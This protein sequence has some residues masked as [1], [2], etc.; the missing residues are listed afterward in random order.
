MTNS[1][2]M[3]TYVVN[4]VTQATKRQD[5]KVNLL[6]KTSLAWLVVH[7]QIRLHFGHHIGE[8]V[9][10]DALL[11]SSEKWRRDDDG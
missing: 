2:D 3:S 8:F 10:M 9:L 5:K 1:T 4:K 7:M 11:P 6:N